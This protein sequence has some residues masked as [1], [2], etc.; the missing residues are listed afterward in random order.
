[1]KLSLLGPQMPGVA[2]LWGLWNCVQWEGQHLFPCTLITPQTGLVE[3]E[4][5]VY[6]AS[7]VLSIHPCYHGTGFNSMESEG[8]NMIS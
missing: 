7:L 2:A 8:W 4:L 1:M 5:C 3:P 6:A